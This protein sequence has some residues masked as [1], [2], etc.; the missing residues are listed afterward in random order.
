MVGAAVAAAFAYAGV[1]ALRWWRAPAVVADH[2]TAT[3]ASLEMRVGGPSELA[4]W[5]VPD[6]EG[7]S[8]IELVLAAE[9]PAMAGEVIVRIEGLAGGEVARPDGGEWPPSLPP[10]ERRTLLREVRVPASALPDGAAFGTGPGA[11][12]SRWTMVRFDPIVPSAG[13]PLLVVVAYPSGGT[14]PGTRVATLARFPGEYRRGELFV[15]GFRA[16]GTMLVRLANDETN[17]A[18]VRRTA[19]NVLAGLPFGTW[20]STVTGALVT[21]CGILLAIVVA[22]LAWGPPRSG[23]SGDER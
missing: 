7:L 23:P 18:S 11:L 20:D 14:Q 1:Q 21:S 3:S 16:G 8:V 6:R 4:Q 10:A 2:V 19:A 9:A 12:A 5:V 22:G 17:A 13:R 15:N